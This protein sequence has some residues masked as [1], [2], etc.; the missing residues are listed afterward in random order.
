MKVFDVAG[1]EPPANRFLFLG[2]YVDRGYFSFECFIYLVALKI[3]YPESIH[4][5]RGNH[6]SRHLTKHF[7]FKA[8]CIYKYSQTV[9]DACMA[10]FD[11]LPLAAL[12]NKQFFC[13]HGG[14]SPE[15]KKP[16][17]LNKVNRLADPPRNG[18][19]CDI[20]WSDPTETFDNEE[21]ADTDVDEFIANGTRGC[22]YKYSYR[23]VINFLERNS[24][25]AVVRGHEAQAA[26]YRLYQKAPGS[27][28]PALITL[29]SAANYVDVYKNKGACLKYDGKVL[30]IRQYVAAPHPY[31]LPKF[32]NVFD[33]SLPFVGEKSTHIWVL[34]DSF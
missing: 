33:W 20:L 1:G 4:L 8:E 6:E 17:D 24:L 23:G 30:N 11:C 19:V 10:A 31:Y 29:F 2:D 14:I 16:H 13:A 18:L 21:Y 32:M 34:L 5:L 3:K 12:V 27:D 15:L 26:G 22:S 25:L 9:Y 7:T 28:F